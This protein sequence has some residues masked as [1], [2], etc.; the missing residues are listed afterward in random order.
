MPLYVYACA[1]GQTVETLRRVAARHDPLACG[2]GKPMA[3]TVAPPADRPAEWNP[4]Y[5]IGLGA[6]VE[7]RA[8]RQRLMR[9]KGVMELGPADTPHGARGT[10]FHGPGMLGRGVTPSGAFARR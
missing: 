4:Y 1:C 3:L 9:E 5:D 10:S 7:G 6:R 8:H 2:C